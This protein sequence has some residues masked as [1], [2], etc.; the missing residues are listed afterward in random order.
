MEL[1]TMYRWIL[2]ALAAV[3][4]VMSFERPFSAANLLWWTTDALEKVRPYD[5]EPKEL[6]RAVNIS[7]A[8]NEFEPFQI[9][10]RMQSADIHGV[11]IDITDL[12][13]PAG[14]AISKNQI[15]PY[16]ERF[17]D[18]K[19]PSSIDG[20]AGEWPDPLVPRVPLRLN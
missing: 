20:G 14:A 12:R 6:N 15:T 10:L 16:L 3:P 19:M 1:M 11:D 8:R 9:V 13:G 17:L 4:L 18:L 5:Q 2:M 7:A